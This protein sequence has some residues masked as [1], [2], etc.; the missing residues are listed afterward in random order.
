MIKNVNFEAIEPSGVKMNYNWVG[1]TETVKLVVL[2]GYSKLIFFQKD[3]TLSEGYNYYILAPNPAKYKIFSFYKRDELIYNIENFDSIVNVSEKDPQ[4][5]FKDLGVGLVEYALAIP[6][7]EIFLYSLY[8]HAHC[9][10][11]KDDVVFDIG[12]NTG[13]FTYYSLYKDVSKVYA[14]EPNP[15]LYKILK[16]K[17]LSN[18]NIENAAVSD[19]DGFTTFLS[20]FGGISS[21]L[22]KYNDSIVQNDGFLA[23]DEDRF[24]RTYIETINLMNYI[25]MENIEKIDYLKCDCEGG[26]YDIIDTLTEEYL[27]NNINKMMIE[28]HYLHNIVFLEKYRKMIAKIISCGFQIQNNSD[29]TVVNDGVLFCWK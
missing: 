6:L 10:V 9:M 1:D 28:Y 3:L 24:Y 19:E 12:S 7:Y 22:E 25:N 11:E 20:S 29:D 21:C 23:R 16:N 26:E 8:D 13:M 14:F 18:I 17:N 4:G 27:T 5:Y 2:D 15:H